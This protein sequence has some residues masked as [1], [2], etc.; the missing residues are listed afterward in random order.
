VFLFVIGE[1][2]TTFEAL[3]GTPLQVPV[4]RPMFIDVEHKTTLRQEGYVHYD[5]AIVD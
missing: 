5:C 2:L 3:I 1:G 4:R